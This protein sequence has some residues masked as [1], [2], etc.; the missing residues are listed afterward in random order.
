MYQFFFLKE[1][2]SLIIK[3]NEKNHKIISHFINWSCQ[4][5]MKSQSPTTYLYH[6]IFIL[7]PYGW[8]D[9][10]FLFFFFFVALENYQTSYDFFQMF[11]KTF[12][13]I[14]CCC[15]CL[16]KKLETKFDRKVINLK[17]DISWMVDFCTT[18]DDR[19]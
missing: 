12:W 3:M 8:H 10:Q 5:S 14:C 4:H 11:L 1:E 9:I 2:N 18:Y 16:T 7:R 19:W 13:F 15:C 6:L 17:F